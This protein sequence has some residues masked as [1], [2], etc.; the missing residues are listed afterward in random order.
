LYAGDKEKEK[1]RV[2]LTFFG[3]KTYIW[4]QQW[5]LVLVKW[6]ILG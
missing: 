1:V 4:F 5:I 6:W 2:V 3:L